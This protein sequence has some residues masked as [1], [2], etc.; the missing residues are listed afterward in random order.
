MDASKKI[1][2]VGKG[3]IDWKS[4]LSHRALAGTKHIFV[5]HDEPKDAFASIRE[6]YRYLSSLRV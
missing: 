3:V 1:V 2:D 4:V 5:E 6:S